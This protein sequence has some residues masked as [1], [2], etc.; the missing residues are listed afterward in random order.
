[1][2]QNSQPSPLNLPP[3]VTH[4]S[5][6]LK[7]RKID[8]AS[9]ATVMVKT[10][11]TKELIPSSDFQ[12]QSHTTT[13]A[14]KSEQPSSSPPPRRLITE[15]C[16]FY[17]LPDDCRKSNPDFKKN[18]Q[19]LFAREYNILKSLG[20]KKTKVFFRFFFCFFVVF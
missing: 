14:I 3:A 1:M 8:D 11:E 16:S 4:P 5:P 17:P 20:L 10:E 6:P 13:R 2:S 9:D 18:R 15:S 19:A 7:R 12:L